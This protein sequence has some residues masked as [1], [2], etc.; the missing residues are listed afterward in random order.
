MLRAQRL[1]RQ[2]HSSLLIQV[3]RRGRFGEVAFWHVLDMV[4]CPT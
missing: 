3:Y 2:S 1:L 4:R